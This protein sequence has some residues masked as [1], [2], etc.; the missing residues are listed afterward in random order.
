MILDTEVDECEIQ[1]QITVWANKNAISL[2]ALSELFKILKKYHP[3]LPSDPRTLL[4]TQ[5][6]Y[7]LKEI[8]SGLYNHFGVGCHVKEKVE[9]SFLMGFMR[10]I[11][12]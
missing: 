3:Q 1:S 6:Q 12:N 5:T 11:Q 10:L 4:K 9:D 7:T 8:C 2:N